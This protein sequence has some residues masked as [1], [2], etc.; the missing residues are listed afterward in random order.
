MVES[1][2]VKPYPISKGEPEVKYILQ[3]GM[4][5]KKNLLGKPPGL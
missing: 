2:W 4:A 3:G 5:G 1:R